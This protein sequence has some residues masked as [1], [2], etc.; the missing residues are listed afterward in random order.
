MLSAR[1]QEWISKREKRWN[2]LLDLK[3]GNIGLIEAEMQLR[4]LDGEE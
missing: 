2:I 1:M 3:L 4:K